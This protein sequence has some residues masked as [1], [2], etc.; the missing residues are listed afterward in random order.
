[1]PKSIALGLNF[2]N[3]STLLLKE[4]VFL[5]YCNLQY[6]S[7]IYAIVVIC[8]NMTYLELIEM[9]TIISFGIVSYSPTT[10]EIQYHV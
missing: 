9:Y 10:L 7:T 2:V 4:I 8:M 1:M 3:L 6:K 5:I